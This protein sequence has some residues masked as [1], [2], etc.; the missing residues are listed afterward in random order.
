M[1][2]RLNPDTEQGSQ[3][4]IPV[5]LPLDSPL[6]GQLRPAIHPA[7]FLLAQREPNKKEAPVGQIQPPEIAKTFD[8][9]VN[10]KA[11]RTRWDDRFFYVESNG[12]PDHRMMVGITAWQQQVPLP[13]KY[14]GDNAW[15][16][17][18]HPAPAKTP[19]STK[20]RF[21]R[22]AI[23]WRRTGFRFS[24][25]LII[26]AMTRICSA[27]WTSSEVTVAGPTTTTITSAG[28]SGEDGR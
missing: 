27:S 3:A 24:I 21:L 15:Q 8:A 22:G 19:A 16:I 6:T 2:G 1:S 20:D 9:Y 23:R 25:R 5:A 10:L 12:I 7:A 28:A 13:Q 17:P 11:I 26:E 14:A 4:I 18:L